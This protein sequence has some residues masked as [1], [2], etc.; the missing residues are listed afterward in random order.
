MLES[1]YCDVPEQTVVALKPRAPFVPVLS[2]CEALV[3]I[4]GPTGLE[5]EVA[6]DPE[7]ERTREFPKSTCRVCTL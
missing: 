2:V 5:S 4:D 7:G 6:G 3:R 1:V